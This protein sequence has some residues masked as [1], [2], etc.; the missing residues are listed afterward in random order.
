[1]EEVV[2][3]RGG[4]VILLAGIL[5][6]ALTLRAPITM[7]GPVLDV[8]RETNGISGGAAGILTALPILAFA[9]ISPI[10]AISAREYGIERSLFAALLLTIGGIGLRSSGPTWAL[11]LGTGILGAGIAVANVLLPS[12]LKRD[13]PARITGLTSAYIVTTGMA[14]AVTSAAVVPLAYL[15][16]SNWQIALASVSIFPLAAL[17]AWFPQLRRHSRSMRDVGTLPVDGKVWHSPLAWHVT[18]FLG[19]TSL[20]FYVL[21]AWLPA[22][23]VDAGYPTNVAGSL[24][25]LLQLMT[26]RKSVV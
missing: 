20:V 25:G 4:D 19:L 15:S 8:I 11:F 6:I 1:M 2:R 3:T 13:F 5:L 14:G 24:Q 16:G 22:I 12:L 9:A 10:A 17:F 21:I 23:L 7:V 18:A 26:D